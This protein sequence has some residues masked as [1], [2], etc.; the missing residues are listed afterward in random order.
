MSSTPKDR[1]KRIS[2]VDALK[3]IDMSKIAPEEMLAL[4]QQNA[5]LKRE[6]MELK[7][8]NSRTRLADQMTPNE[9]NWCVEVLS[10]VRVTFDH[11]KDAPVPVATEPVKL[12][13]L[14]DC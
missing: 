3:Q 6:V 7:E 10:K 11:V 9:Y 2:K 8:A 4:I 5:D 14:G 13:S 12:I 1:Q